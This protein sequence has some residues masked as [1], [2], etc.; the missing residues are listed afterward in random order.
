MHPKDL[1]P[2]L[3]SQQ[4]MREDNFEKLDELHERVGDLRLLT[5][6]IHSTVQ[7]QNT[8]LDDLSEEMSGAD[9][10]L[11]IVLQQLKKAMNTKNASFCG[12]T[13]VVVLFILALWVVIK[14]I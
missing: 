3:E 9:D 10:K 8:K 4:I 13:L 12:I 5:Q 14:L 7:R 2:T 1:P 11:K 6:D